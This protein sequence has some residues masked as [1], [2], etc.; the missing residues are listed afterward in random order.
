MSF[1]FGTVCTGI[2]APE[3]AWHP[4]GAQSVWMAE[5]DKAANHV[6]AY[7]FPGVPNYGDMTKL[8]ERVRSGEVSAPTVFCGGTPCQSFSLAGL[9]AGMADPRGQLTLSYVDIINAIDDA[10]QQSGLA[11]A[12]AVWENVPGVLTHK[13][14]PFG[15][16][17]A[18]LAGEDQPLQP[19]GGKWTHAGCVF[20]PQRAIAWRLLDAQYFRLAQRRKRLIVV[21]SARKGFDPARVLFEWGDVRRD[22]PP[23]RPG[24]EDCLPA[25]AF[26]AGG[27]DPIAFALRG[28]EGGA[29][30]EVHRH[31]D[32]VGALRSANGGSSWDYVAVDGAI[33]RL[34][35]VE[36]ER[37]QGFP[38]GH[39]DVAGVGDGQR[40]SQIGN[41]MAV[42]MM[43]WIGER[44]AG[45]LAL[46]GDQFV[47]RNSNSLLTTPD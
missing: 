16:F 34:F 21:T 38:D 3:V 31:G 8:A 29:V 30:P 18:G 4:L 15:C 24:R 46:A 36:G 10:R 40:R 19:P 14:N 17:L 41:S 7:R 44:L 35:T 5:V 43:R 28:R 2:G 37:L 6:L 13:D 25:T 23:G 12:V 32:T 1:D 22:S 33:R 26:E 39:T 45:E 9:R 42:P 20:G 47:H 11:P 27:A